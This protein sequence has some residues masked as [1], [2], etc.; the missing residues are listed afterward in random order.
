MGLSM[1]SST[2]TLG[3][4]LNLLNFSSK[5]KKKNNSSKA[6]SP[7]PQVTTLGPRLSALSLFYFLA[8]GRL[9]PYFE[10][11]C[12]RLATPAVSSVPRTM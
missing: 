11:R 12:V 10:R 4:L 1:C 3:H 8:L 7:W 6:L 5:T 9:A 2:P